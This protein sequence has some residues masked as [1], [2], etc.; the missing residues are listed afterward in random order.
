[1]E[2][3]FRPEEA[4][5]IGYANELPDCSNEHRKDSR[6]SPSFSVPQNYQASQPDVSSSSLIHNRRKPDLLQP[7]ARESCDINSLSE[8]DH[9]DDLISL[10]RQLESER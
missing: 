3:H 7:V 8:V 1:M 9:N 4:V 2:P 5:L 6:T 10:I